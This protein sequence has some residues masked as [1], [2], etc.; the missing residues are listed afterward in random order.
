MI[1]PLSLT[2]LDQTERERTIEASSTSPSALLL[3]LISQPNAGRSGS[4]SV[5]Q[6]SAVNDGRLAVLNRHR[7][8]VPD[9]FGLFAPVSRKAIAGRKFGHGVLDVGQ[10]SCIV[11]VTEAVAVGRTELQC[12]RGVRGFHNKQRTYIIAFRYLI[13]TSSNNVLAAMLEAS[14][15][16]CASGTKADDRRR[17]R[18]WRASIQ[19]F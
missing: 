10:I 14:E 4:G 19:R 9:M 8:E 12:D 15:Y 17:S 2:I 6:I 7:L 13:V 16:N 11:Y 18:V 5:I 1:S 3:L